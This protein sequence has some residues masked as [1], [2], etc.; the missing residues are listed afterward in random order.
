MYIV[1]MHCDSLIHV[2]GDKGIINSYNFSAKYPHLQFAAAFVP[3]R[4][5]EAR[6][7]RLELM[8]HFNVYLSEKERL[9][10]IGV[11]GSE[12][13]YKFEEE[14]ARSCLFSVE[15]GAGLFADS[16]ELEV[17]AMGGLRVLSLA[18]DKNE[19]AS[20]AWDENDEGLTELGRQMLKKCDSLGIINDVSHLSDKSFYELIE[21]SRYPVLATHS[22]FRELCNS[23]RNLTRDM[24]KMI[25]ER[26]GV[27]GLNLYP[28]FLRE[29]G[30]ADL[31]D[32][33]RHVDYALEN[34]GDSY[35]GFG[36]DIDGVDSY[37]TG[38]DTSASIHDQV[39]D[40]LLHNY[41]R[42]TVEK[43]AGKNVINFLK[44]NLS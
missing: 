44:N 17:L 24:A 40:L 14:E 9:G 2:G 1:D 8:Q 16:S 41:P 20:S 6:E 5:R 42:E 18:W 3:K 34:F 7:R 10:M 32:I 4:G 13:V 38:I 11:A 22:N 23:P 36:F 25:V 15:G 12:D 37:P 28:G 30:K 35:L 26:G 43:I 33:I 39:V 19:L 29:G 31:S 27:I 21:T